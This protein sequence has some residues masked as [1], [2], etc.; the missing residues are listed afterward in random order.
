MA[1]QIQSHVTVWAIFGVTSG[2]DKDQVNVIS[3]SYAFLYASVH[4]LSLPNPRNTRFT[5]TKL[6]LK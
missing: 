2:L 1:L 4:S 5:A 3:L 6:I